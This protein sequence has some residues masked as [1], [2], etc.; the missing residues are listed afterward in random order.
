MEAGK[1]VAQKRELQQRV[2][3][4][5]HDFEE[6]QRSTLE[7]TTSMTLQYKSMQEGLM[8]RINQL[9]K[10]IMDLKDQLGA[11]ARATACAR[12]A[13]LTRHCM[14]KTLRDWRWRS[15]SARRS[16][17]WRQRT[18]RLRACG[19]AWMR[20]RTSLA[21][22]SRCAAAVAGACPRSVSRRL[23]TAGSAW[24]CAQDTLEKMSERIEVSNSSWERE[25]GVPMLRK[26]EEH[27]L[28]S[29]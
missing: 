16:R 20:W 9:E 4:L 13:A 21:T 29:S 7:I 18:P 26:L 14:A 3:Q 23:L 5:Q 12:A 10:T 6:E 22:C 27:G 1:A 2:Q 8:N 11:Q 28:G 25:T 15:A 19:N 24:L 17:S